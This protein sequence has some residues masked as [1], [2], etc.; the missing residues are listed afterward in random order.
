M[1]FAK[2]R[3]NAAEIPV[4]RIEEILT[5]RA[6]PE[7][8]GNVEIGIR[9]LETAG[10]EVEITAQIENHLPLGRSNEDAEPPV[11]T[12]NRVNSVRTEINKIRERL[13]VGTTVHAIRASFVRGELR[14]FKLVEVE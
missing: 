13:I 3:R 12:H 11:I 9:V 2:I 6:V 7:F 1:G 14:S 4:D 8:T 5:Q 10:L